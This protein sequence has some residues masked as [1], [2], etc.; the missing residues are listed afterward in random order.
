M[1]DV[2]RAINSNPTLAGGNIVGVE[3]EAAVTGCGRAVV[4]EWANTVS[5]YAAPT[6]LVAHVVCMDQSCTI[7]A[8]DGSEQ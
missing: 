7:G 6:R 5:P 2:R 3:E 8:I 1:A 4:I